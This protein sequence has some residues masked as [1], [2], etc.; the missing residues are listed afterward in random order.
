VLLYITRKLCSLV[1]LVDIT[2]PLPG[3][4]WDSDGKEGTPEMAFS[5]ETVSKHANW[6]GFHDPESGIAAYKVDK[7]TKRNHFKL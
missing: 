6:S 3:T 4:V 5:S 2:P 1:V 7:C